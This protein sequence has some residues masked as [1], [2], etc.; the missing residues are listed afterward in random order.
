[1]SN[2][3]S[4]SYS[5]Y[6]EDNDGLHNN[7]QT[8]LLPSAG[9]SSYEHGSGINNA[10]LSTLSRSRNRQQQS[11]RTPPGERAYH[12]TERNENPRRYHEERKGRK[13][14]KLGGRFDRGR[15]SKHEKHRHYNKHDIDGFSRYNRRVVDSFRHSK[16]SIDG[17]RHDRRYKNGSR[18][19]KHHRDHYDRHGRFRH[20]RSGKDEQ[21]RHEGH[22]R[23]G[24]EFSDDTYSEY[25]GHRD[26]PNRKIYNLLRRQR[27]RLMSEWRKELKEQEEALRAEREFNGWYNRMNRWLGEKCI[28]VGS[29]TANAEQFISNL[30]LAIGAIALAIVTLGI[31]W[32]KF[33]EEKNIP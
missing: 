28:K 10:Q 15:T 11:S 13:K 23:Y 9:I 2:S 16:Q 17:Q 29:Y 18:H 12:R 30:P 32:F 31:V 4:E 24:D 7:E 1:M 14:E 21:Y 5:S 27:E 8:A 33:A 19:C 6:D 22:N 26:I 3:T 25:E 20:N